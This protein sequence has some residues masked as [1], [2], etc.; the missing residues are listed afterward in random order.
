MIELS[1]KTDLQT[2]QELPVWRENE[3]V[4]HAEPAGEGNMNLVL[5]VKTNYRSVILKQS[6]TYVRK[7]PQIPAPVE[8]I[9]VEHKFY[10]LLQNHP[11]LHQYSPKILAY[12]PEDHIL[13]TQ[14]LGKGSDFTKMYN[15]D[16]SF[17]ESDFNS[18]SHYLNH[19][20][21]IQ[22]ID[23]P[24][25]YSMKTLNHEHLFLFP[26]EPENGLDLD[27]IQEGLQKL[28]HSYKHDT[29]LKTELR[30]LGERY[31]S[32][33]NTLLH[34]DFYPGSW[35]STSGGLKVI[36]PEFGFLGDKEFDLGI[37]LAHFDLAKVDQKVSERFMETYEHSYD[38][39]LLKAYQGME[40]LRRL[41]GI[42]QLPVSLELKEKEELMKKARNLI[43]S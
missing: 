41:I 16:F 26:F 36:D 30:Q 11:A 1:E 35:L 29:A 40:I 22:G 4:I 9:Q 2:I 43:L 23:F 39:D 18:L 25:N 42:A 3:K 17:N 7:F 20:H 6:K 8:R 37:L 34:G 12:L 13:V 19:L 15:P 31:L 21:G 27:N 33:G 24:D 32:K 28:S 38:S 5:R 14:D 10:E